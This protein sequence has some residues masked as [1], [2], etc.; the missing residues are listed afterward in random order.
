MIKTK[1]DAATRRKSS[2]L[3]LDS[4][5][6]LSQFLKADNTGSDNQDPLEL[7]MDLID[8]DPDQPRTVFD[9]TLLEDMASTIATR[10]VK[11]PISVHKHPT[12]EGRYIINDGARRY[13]ASRLAG[14]KTIKAFIDSDFTKIDQIIVNAHHETFT[15]REWAVLIDQELKKGKK[16]FEIADELGMSRAAIT[17]LSALLHLPDPIMHLFNT[18][19]FVDPTGLNELVVMW[20]VDAKKVETWLSD[21]TMEITRAA[22]RKFH[23][24]METSTE[25]PAVANEDESYEK[26]TEEQNDSEKDTKT[27]ERD[28]SKLR[29]TI[30]QVQ[31]KGRPAQLQLTRRPSATGQAWLKYDDDGKELEIALAQVKL[32]AILEG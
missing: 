28:Y 30:V 20:N 1:S 31:H 11:N 17:H 10:G 14:K 21:E 6:D 13:R 15:S 4:M 32:V 2:G 24:F 26:V 19:R 18:G 23:R 29:K 3:G 12:E 5:T 25:A 22:V 8:E 7:D 9:K 16:K 27:K